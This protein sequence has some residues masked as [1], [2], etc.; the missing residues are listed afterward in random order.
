M[1]GV[2]YGY[3]VLGVG[4]N[5]V[6]RGLDIKSKA[7]AAMIAASAYQ[8]IFV[9]NNENR[10]KYLEAIETGEMLSHHI[11]DAISIAMYAGNEIRLQEA[12]GA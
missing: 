7:H 11:S 4:A 5:K 12:I 2:Q 1:I 6:K 3:G 8:D 10:G 9:Y